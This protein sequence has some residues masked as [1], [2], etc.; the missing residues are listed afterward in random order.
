MLEVSLEK[1]QVKIREEE[2]C[3]HP[4]SAA[5]LH[6]TRFGIADGNLHKFPS[7]QGKDGMVIIRALAKAQIEFPHKYGIDVRIIINLKVLFRARNQSG[8]HQSALRDHN[9][10]VR[11]LHSTLVDD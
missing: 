7:V 10:M 4:L 9:R 1:W 5:E 2:V 6:F 8:E 11:V 3:S